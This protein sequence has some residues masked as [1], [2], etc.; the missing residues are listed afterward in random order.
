MKK[1][2]MSCVTFHVSC[3]TGCVSQVMCH[4][5]HVMCRESP[6]TCHMSLT[7]TATAT[8]PPT[9]KSPTMQNRLVCKDPKTRKKFNMQ[10]IIKTA[11]TQKCLEVFQKSAVHTEVEFP[12]RDRQTT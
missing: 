8:D 9:A 2:H 6:V 12:R 11:K 1:I 10:K 4:V 3:V 5:L 7:P